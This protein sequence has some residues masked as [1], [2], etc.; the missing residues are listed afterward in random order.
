MIVGGY[1]LH[2]YCDVLDESYQHRGSAS[3]PGDGTGDFCGES[4]G[5]A[6]QD[7]R[8]AGWKFDLKGGRVICP[9]CLK[10]GKTLD[11]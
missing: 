7:A 11:D 2:L 8:R 3:F 5:N 9:S 10:A 6:R 1:S 4:G